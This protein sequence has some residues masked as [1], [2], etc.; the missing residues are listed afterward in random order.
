MLRAVDVL[1]TLSGT[2]TLVRLVIPTDM[3]VLSAGC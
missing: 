3:H 2:T 1:A